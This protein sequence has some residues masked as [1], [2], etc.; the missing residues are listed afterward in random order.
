[1]LL[2]EN[3]HKKPSQQIDLAYTQIFYNLVNPISRYTKL[4]SIENFEQMNNN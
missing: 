2:I 1:L 4:N 3:F